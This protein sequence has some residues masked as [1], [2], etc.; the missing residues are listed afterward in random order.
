MALIG[1]AHALLAPHLTGAV[2]AGGFAGLGLV[3]AWHQDRKLLRLRGERYAAYVAATSTIPFAAILAGRQRL[4]LRELPLGALAAGVVVAA[5]LR[6]R[7]DSLFANGGLWLLAIV[8]GGAA[9]QVVQ[10]WRRGRRAA[11]VRA[12]LAHDTP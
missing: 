4:V 12:R 11:R 3:G 10:G 5:L 7:H 2:F 9:V 8:L 1:G 6:A